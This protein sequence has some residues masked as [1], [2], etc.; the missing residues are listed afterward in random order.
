[1]SW[2]VHNTADST[3]SERYFVDLY[4]DDLVVSRWIGRAL[5][6][7]EIDVVEDWAD[8]SDAVSLVPGVHVLKLVV[9]ST[10]LIAE[11]DE[12]DNTYELEIVWK[13]D[14]LTFSLARERP[15]TRLPDLAV[16]QLRGA[17]D[18]IVASSHGD[19]LVDSL[20]SVD[21]PTHVVSGFEN[22]GLSSV[23]GL[24]R[25]DLY[26]DDILVTWRL[27][28]GAVA[29]ST[30]NRILWPD[31]SSYVRL[32]PGL[33]T[34]RIVL[35]PNNLIEESDETNNVFEKEFVW[36]T[37][38]VPPQPTPV[39]TPPTVLPQP[40][41]L[42]NLQPGWAF[43]TDGPVVL[44]H[45]EDAR[46]N[47]PL[48]VGQD[49]I[50]RATVNNRSSVRTL[51]PFAVN[52]Y[53]DDKL[54]NTFSFQRGLPQGATASLQWGGLT[55]EVDVTEGEHTVRMVIDARDSVR[56]ANEE[57][58]VFEAVFE[59]MLEPPPEPEPTVYSPDQIARMLS[60][61]RELVDSADV[62]VSAAGTDHTA[63][64][65][66]IVDAGYY[67][68]SGTSL[69]DE[70]ADIIILNRA[71]YLAWIDKE[72]QDQYARA[73]AREMP[74]VHLR[75]R[76]LRELAIGFT[77]R[78]L[79]RVVVVV[80]GERPLPVVIDT[81]AHEVAH[82]RQDILNP[83]QQEVA[84]FDPMMLGLLEA[85]AQ[86]F[87]RAFWLTLEEFTGETF[88]AYPSADVFRDLIAQRAFSL[89]RDAAQDE[90]ALGYLLQW[91]FAMDVPDLAALA[92]ELAEQGG[93]SA[94]SSMSLYDY[95]VGLS[96]E[97]AL[98]LAW[99]LYGRAGSDELAALFDTIVSVASDRLVSDLDPDDEGLANLRLVGLLS[100]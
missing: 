88:T 73:G 14:E 96:P 16:V 24:L 72:F 21:V 78:R 17:S 69:R 15:V 9:D 23:V 84:P 30:S 91:A 90:H 31:L 75:H 52:I 48:I 6:P 79:G 44:S 80:D 59:W 7:G 25:V 92:T 38:P 36:N 40:L 70:R 63:K 58:N 20:L 3:I 11:T 100:P 85:Q 47:S 60:G 82:M 42:S 19:S 8:I 26:Y 62:A 76:R 56:E 94:Q 12:S 51:I 81:L 10:D 33:H 87:Q 41:S 97:E 95:L 83:A 67:L 64:V 98:A 54:V 99:R 50:L 53:F 2:G 13:A 28:E 77:S 35:D 93:L 49:V 55:D 18:V 5:A 32:T 71:D 89:F 57:D 22:R 61:L 74:H 4:F 86:Q 66:E 45:L 27:G 39:P 1:M 37:G 34:L 46:F 43:D 68:I 65:L 29:G